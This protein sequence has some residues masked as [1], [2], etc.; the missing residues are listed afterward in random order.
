LHL[1]TSTRTVLAFARADP[2]G[3]LATWLPLGAH[4]IGLPGRAAGAG[5]YWPLLLVVVLYVAAFA[6]PRVRRRHV[7]PIHG[8][9]ASHLLVL[10]LFEADTYGYRLVMPMYAPMLVVAAQ[11]PIALAQ[12]ATSHPLRAARYGTR[13]FARPLRGGKH[14]RAG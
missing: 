1:D 8:F 11:V 14:Q 12:W 3:Y 10:M 6:L 9:V 4:S 13:R 7:W 2:F 5:V